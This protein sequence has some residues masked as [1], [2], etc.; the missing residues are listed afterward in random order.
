MLVVP[1]ERE[2][3]KGDYDNLLGTI[4]HTVSRVQSTGGGGGEDSPPNSLASPPKIANE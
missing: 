4:K 1:E 2:K 3:L